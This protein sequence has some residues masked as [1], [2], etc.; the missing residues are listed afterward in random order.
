MQSEHSVVGQE[1][2]H[3]A[4]G[5]M[6]VLVDGASTNGEYSLLLATTLVGNTTP[7]HFHD[8]DSETLVMLE[9]SMTV[10]TPGRSTV[11]DA[12]TAATLVSGK[13]HRLSNAGAEDARYL[14][15]CAP[16]G[17]EEFVRRVGTPVDSAKAV[18]TQMTEED[19]RLMVENAADYGVR[20]T[21]GTELAQPA[22]GDVPAAR[23]ETFVAFGTTIDVLARINDGRDDIV[24]IR[25][26]AIRPDGVQR[27]V[28]AA[29]ADADSRYFA[30]TGALNGSRT[31]HFASAATPTLLAVTTGSVLRLLREDVMSELIICDGGPIGRLQLVLTAL[32]ASGTGQATE[33]GLFPRKPLNVR[34]GFPI[35]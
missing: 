9:G 23:K 1:T 33:A 5:L 11:L 18:P 15:L 27:P 10:E 8:I 13:V 14:L 17:F 31:G 26:A 19:V 32:H 25:A 35:H 6:T 29:D 4:G 34:R 16:S 24:L 2:Y 28:Q 30:G 12:G 22:S 7:P 3:F 20:L 21:D